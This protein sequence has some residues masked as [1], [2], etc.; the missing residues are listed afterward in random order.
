MP[1]R[2]EYERGEAENHE[3]LGPRLL[4]HEENSGRCQEQDGGDSAIASPPYEGH[5]HGRQFQCDQLCVAMI[6]GQ[7]L[8]GHRQQEAQW[9][10]RITKLQTAVDAQSRPVEL[11]VTVNIRVRERVRVRPVTKRSDGVALEDMHVDGRKGRLV[12]RP[13]PEREVSAHERANLQALR[14]AAGA[15]EHRDGRGDAQRG[16]APIER[17][18]RVRRK[19]GNQDRGFRVEAVPGW[20]RA[21]QRRQVARCAHRVERTRPAAESQLPQSPRRVRL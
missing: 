9:K 21:R 18:Q 1:G 4:E 12:N 17:R 2:D 13:H 3:G 8:P 15:G 7:Q 14:H 19:A 10:V 6:A 20:P 11:S 16:Q 5:Q